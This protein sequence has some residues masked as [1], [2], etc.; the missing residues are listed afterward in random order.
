MDRSWLP[1]AA[2]GLG[3][4]GAVVSIEAQATVYL[5]VA[6][7][8]QAMFP[9][10]LLSAQELRLDD[11]QRAAIAQASG[12]RSSAFKPQVW[13]APEGGWFLVDAVIGKS[14]LI[15]YALGLNADGHVRQLEILE[16]RESHG[17]EVRYPRWRDQF[18][19]KGPDDPVALGEDIQGISGA[20]LSCEHLTAGVKRLLATWDLVLRHA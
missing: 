16:Y 7:A 9:A 2:L 1:L 10:Q 14:E 13:R 8:Q 4:L 5:S 12:M 17:G 15:T 6:E 18:K 20:T 11:A 19:G 3:S